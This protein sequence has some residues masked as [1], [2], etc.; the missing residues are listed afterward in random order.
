M[1]EKFGLELVLELY[2]KDFERKSDALVALLHWALLNGGLRCVGKGE[3]FGGNEEISP[4]ELLP[5]GWRETNE[6][7]YILKYRH[8]KTKTSKFVLKL[9]RI[10]KEDPQ[11]TF[12]VVLVRVGDEESRSITVRT[13]E[14]FDD[15]LKATNEEE[16]LS[17]FDAKI[18]KDLLPKE[19]E[20]KEQPRRDVLLVSET[21]PPLPQQP[22]QRGPEV[23]PLRD[24]FF[25][26][27]ESDLDPFG[28]IGSGGMLADP[29][30]PRRGGGG[31]A[32]PRFDP[33]GPAF[34]GAGPSFPGM[35]GRGGRGGRGGGFGGGR[36]FGDEM[37]P[38]DF[39]NMFM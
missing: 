10:D 18:L 12:E 14:V 28:R 34:P 23:N 4:T 38:P 32:G 36:N 21:R 20:S 5:S 25:G 24:P 8:A 9:A 39:D 16:L 13:E 2:N 7:L 31:L 11:G 17:E 1:S 29:L 22:T 3:H 15:S 30:A 19:D 27:G 33:P 35:G 37:P 6:T 26:I